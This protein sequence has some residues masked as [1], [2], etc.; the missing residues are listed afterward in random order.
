MTQKEVVACEWKSTYKQV[1]CRGVNFSVRLSSD[2][3]QNL[4]MKRSTMDHA[5]EKS[6]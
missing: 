5:V 2:M 4:R 1:G 3:E 6:F